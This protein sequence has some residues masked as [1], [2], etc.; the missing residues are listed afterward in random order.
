MCLPVLRARTSPAA[1]LQLQPPSMEFRVSAAAMVHLLLHLMP[2]QRPLVAHLLLLLPLVQFLRCRM[3]AR[4]HPTC[5]LLM[6]CMPSTLGRCTPTCMLTHMA[7]HQLTTH[8]VGRQVS[9]LRWV[10]TGD[11]CELP[12]HLPTVQAHFS[13][14]RVTLKGT[15]RLRMFDPLAACSDNWHAVQWQF[16]MDLHRR[17]STADMSW[18]V[19][20]AHVDRCKCCQSS[21]L[22]HQITILFSLWDVGSL[23]SGSL[24]ISGRR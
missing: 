6:A 20:G 16:F 9:R 1:M 10:D 14:S 2:H 13:S 15:W 24:I 21:H 3:V 4:S 5:T 22:Q 11:S 18:N 8:M 12:M 19:C 17:L 23:N 7:T